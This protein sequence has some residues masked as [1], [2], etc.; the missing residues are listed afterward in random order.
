MT[1]QGYNMNTPIDEGVEYKSR[2][3]QRMAEIREARRTGGLG[4]VGGVL[5]I[6]LGI[7][8]MLV[9]MDVIHSFENWWALFFLIPAAGT[10]SAAVGLYR[11]ND[12]PRTAIGPFIAGVFFLLMTA[13][14][15]FDFDFDWFWPLLL[16]AAGLLILF[17]AVFGRRESDSNQ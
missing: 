15:L 4:W 2:R 12:D 5:L 17:G 13:A 7:V 6:G 16:I 10:L 8:T 14:F 11:R 3:R 9:N 1:E